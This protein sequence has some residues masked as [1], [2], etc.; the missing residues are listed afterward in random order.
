[1]NIDLL[2]TASFAGGHPHDQYDWLR[3]HAPVY[4]HDEPGGRGFWAITHYQDVYDIG[5]NAE[6]F[7]SEPTIMIAEPDE[8]LAT[9][10]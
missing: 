9:N 1:M 7:S 4:F 8:N 5:R 10:A 6:L 2:N 3:Q